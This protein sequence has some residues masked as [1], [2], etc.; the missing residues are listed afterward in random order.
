M[1][2]LITL[3]LALVM[4]FSLASCGS[5]VGFKEGT[6]TNNDVY[7]QKSFGITY[8]APE[9][10][11]FYTDEQIAALYGTTVDVLKSNTLIHY[12]MQCANP[13]TNGS[14]TI[15]YED[16]V[17]LYG[18]VI[19]D[20]SYLALS[21]ASIKASFESMEGVKISAMD[22]DTVVIDGKEYNG[23]YITIDVNGKEFYETIFVMERDGIM[24]CCT[25]AAYD[26]AELESILAG[27]EI[28]A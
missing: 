23:T 15:T 11:T 2:K 22:T 6:V 9:G 24:M 10:Y 27:F 7:K 13:A 3:L 18:N 26:E 21:Q 12:D 1:K 5:D 25:A 17:G 4:V 16:L 8:T 14:L 20:E 28:A 19:N